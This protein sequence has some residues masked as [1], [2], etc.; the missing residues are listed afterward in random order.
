MRTTGSP[1]VENLQRSHTRHTRRTSHSHRPLN[2][3]RPLDSSKVPKRENTHRMCPLGGD[4]MHSSFR[5]SLDLATRLCHHALDDEQCR[6]SVWYS[7]FTSHRMCWCKLRRWAISAQH[8]GRWTSV[9]CLRKQRPVH[10]NS[11]EH[12]WKITE[13]CRAQTPPPSQMC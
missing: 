12:F 1:M 4:R 7:T 8:T 11:E 2:R 10:K 3:L 13:S 6:A 5:W 9:R